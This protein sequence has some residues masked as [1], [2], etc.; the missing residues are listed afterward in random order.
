MFTCFKKMTKGVFFDRDGII[1]QVIYDMVLGRISTPLN[2]NQ[3][4]LVPKIVDLLRLTKQKGYLNIIV[5]NQPMIGLKRISEDGFATITDRV[6]NLLKKENAIIDDQFYCFHHPYALIPKYKKKCSC[7]KPGID[8]ITQ[9]QKKHDI[10]L[11]K[12]WFIGDGTFDIIAGHKSGCKTILVTNVEESAY[13]HEF[14]KR[15]GKVK[16]DFIVKNLGEIKHFF[17]PRGSYHID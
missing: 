16:P 17:D 5:S 2:P 7:R 8:L 9:A 12:S 10:D 11:K 13:L 1:N 14:E 6:V 3:I 15:L 4:V